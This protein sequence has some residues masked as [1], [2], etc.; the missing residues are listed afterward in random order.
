MISDFERK[1]AILRDDILIDDLERFMVETNTQVEITVLIGIGCSHTGIRR[2]G[3]I[4][5]NRS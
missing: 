2:P 5:M 4:S 3:Q 1:L